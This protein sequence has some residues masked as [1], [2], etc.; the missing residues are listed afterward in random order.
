[1]FHRSIKKSKPVWTAVSGGHTIINAAL[2]AQRI[3]KWARL[4]A[5]LTASE[6]SPFEP[7]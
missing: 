1:M 3:L 7:D 5:P 4:T 6:A 2:E